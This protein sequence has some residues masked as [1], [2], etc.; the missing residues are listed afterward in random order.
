MTL[1]GDVDGKIA[2]LV[3]DMADTCG[4]FKLAAE[5]LKKKRCNRNLCFVHAWSVVWQCSEKN[6]RFSTKRISSYQF[7]QVD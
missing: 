4:T 3:D 6:R 1:V 2:I 5:T 7:Y